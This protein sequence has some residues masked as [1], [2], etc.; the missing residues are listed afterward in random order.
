[1]RAVD[2]SLKVNEVHEAKAPSLPPMSL[3]LHWPWCV[4]K[5][6]YCDFNSHRAPA[7]LDE[8]RY[9]EAMLV[10][11]AAWPEAAKGRPIETIFL[12]GGTPSLMSGEAL[13]RLLSGVRS[14]WPVA[15]DAEIT[16]EANPGTADEAK[17]ERFRAAGVNRLSLGIQSFS[18][19]RL[20]RLGRIHDAAGARRAVAAAAR[21]FENFNLDL[22]FA[23]PGETLEMLRDEA[24]EAADSAATHLS[25]YQLT[26]EEGTAFAKRPPT[27]LPDEDLAADMGELVERV[28]ADAGFRRYEVSGYA[29]E[30][31]RCRHN[32]NYWTYGD[33]V[34]AG[35]GAHGKVTLVN[36]DG[37]FSVRREARFASP[38]KYLAAVESCGSGAE[39]AF[40]VEPEARPFEFMLNALRLAEGVPAAFFEARTGL[41]LSLI[42]PKLDELRAS[43]LLVADPARIAPTEKGL[44][45]LSDLQEAFLPEALAES[46]GVSGR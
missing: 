9:V 18:D 33:Y 41:S 14:I 28:L 40:E 29:K 10:D 3:Y 20:K 31:R 46:E 19:E 38:A 13:K 23:L 7:G 34:A 4:R 42:E 25:F 17:F 16:L 32:L 12:G 22:M 6:P 21:V 45:F 43:G 5:C 8:A 30:G 35:A 24:R 27:D 44:L 2:E 11:L 26:I 37:T 15:K 36:P 1:M 39:T